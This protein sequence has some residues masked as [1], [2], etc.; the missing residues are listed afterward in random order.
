MR[1]SDWSSDVCSSDLQNTQGRKAFTSGFVLVLF[2]ILK[3]PLRS[4]WRLSIA[5]GFLLISISSPCL[6]SLVPPWIHDYS[7]IFLTSTGIILVV[8]SNDVERIDPVAEE[9]QRVL[10]EEQEIGRAHV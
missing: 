8:D 1:I 2:C 7:T 4:G 3:R 6:R 9:L 10:A 5:K